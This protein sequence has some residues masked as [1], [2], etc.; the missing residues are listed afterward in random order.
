MVRFLTGLGLRMR[1]PAAIFLLWHEKAP[2]PPPSSKHE[3]SWAS[4]RKKRPMSVNYIRMKQG[5]IINSAIVW[6]ARSFPPLPMKIGYYP[7]KGDVAMNHIPMVHRTFRRRTSISNFTSHYPI[8]QNTIQYKKTK[9]EAYA[10]KLHFGVGK[11]N[12]LIRRTS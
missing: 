2:C 1:P 11:T 8:F 4:L 12:R 5:S 7:I 3:K 10:M 6:S 9:K